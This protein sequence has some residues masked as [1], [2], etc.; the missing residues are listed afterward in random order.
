MV[1]PLIHEVVIRSVGG[2]PFHNL[3]DI[4][5]KFVS[6]PV[7]HKKSLLW[8][9][10]PDFSAGCRSDDMSISYSDVSEE[11]ASYIFTYW[12]TSWSRVLLVKLTVFLLVKKFPSFYGTWKFIAAFKIPRHLSISI[13]STPPHPFLK[14]HLNIILPSTAGSP[15][16]AS[17]PQ[18]SPPK[19]WIRLSSLPYALHAYIFNCD[20]LM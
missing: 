7:F 16:V 3:T 5:D 10:F 14:I 13:Q 8:C 17:F 15:Q 6:C 2:K 9:K 12:L 20:F 1:T 18:V 4:F 19:P 11:Q